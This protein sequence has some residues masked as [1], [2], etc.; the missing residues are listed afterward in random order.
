MVRPHLEYANVIWHATLKKHL[1]AIEK[2]QRSATKIVHE[3]YNFSYAERLEPLDLP[4]IKYIQTRSDLIQT[5]K[6]IH[7]IDNV[8]IEEFFT[9]SQ[10]SLE[11]GTLN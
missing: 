9:M 6:I 4:S 1:I 10:V 3:K 7:N 8:N 5:Y 11:L 2:V